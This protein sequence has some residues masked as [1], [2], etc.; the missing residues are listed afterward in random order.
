LLKLFP[1]AIISASFGSVFGC[2]LAPLNMLNA[3][4]IVININTI[5]NAKPSYFATVSFLPSAI[6]KVISILRLKSSKINLR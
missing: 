4:K 6:V 1:L 5:K 3:P 2:C